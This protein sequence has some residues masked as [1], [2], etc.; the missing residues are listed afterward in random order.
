MKSILL[1]RTIRIKRSE[2]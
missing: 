2:F 1:L